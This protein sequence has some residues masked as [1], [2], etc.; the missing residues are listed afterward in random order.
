MRASPRCG[1]RGQQLTQVANTNCTD[2]LGCELFCTGHTVLADG[3]LLVAGGHDEV[4]GNSYGLTQSSTFDGTGWT[5]SGRMHYPRWYP[6]LVSLENGQVVAISG[7]QV[8]GQ[9]ASIPERWDG[10]GWTA[11]TGANLKI[12]TTLGSSS[13]RRTDASSSPVTSSPDSSI[14]PGSAPGPSAPHGG[15]PTATTAR[16]SCWTARSCTPAGAGSLPRHPG[17]QRRA[18]RP[19]RR[20]AI[21]ES[22]RVDGRGAPSAQPHD[23]ARRHR[24]GHRR[25]QHLWRQ[26]RGRC[27][28]LGRA[29]GAGDGAVEDA[30]ERGRGPRVPLHRDAAAR[31]EG[32]VDRRRRRRRRTPHAPTRSAR[33][34][35]CSRAIGR[36]TTSRPRPCAMGSRSP[37]APPMRRRSGR[38]PSSGCH[39]P[40][41]P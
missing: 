25:D 6:S 17:T 5:P 10:T 39:P 16:P 4:R 19:R 7:S 32:P 33:R 12:R 2:P 13:S 38:S 1:T 14:P 3:R 41:M 15:F 31:R 20:V 21:V 36:P 8:P 40:R 27:R 11:L 26:R 9:N 30:L 29:V 22:H 24:A 28:V 18:H 37:S 35:T 23:P 34:P